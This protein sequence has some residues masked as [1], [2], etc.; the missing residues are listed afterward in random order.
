[1]KREGF[2]SIDFLWWRS[3]RGLSS[4]NEMVSGLVSVN[5]TW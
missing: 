1:M 4:S 5:S 3:W 2:I